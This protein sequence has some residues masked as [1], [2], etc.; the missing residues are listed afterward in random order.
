MGTPCRAR[1]GRVMVVKGFDGTRKVVEFPVAY[2]TE[3]VEV[4]TPD[5]VLFEGTVDEAVDEADMHR[6][7]AGKADEVVDEVVN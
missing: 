2:M 5:T 3:A 1:A 6:S 4:D 7:L